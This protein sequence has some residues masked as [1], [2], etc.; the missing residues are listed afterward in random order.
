MDRIKQNQAEKQ[1]IPFNPYAT[2]PSKPLKKES[3]K[4]NLPLTSAAGAAKKRPFHGTDSSSTNDVLRVLDKVKADGFV[5][6]KTKT[7]RINGKINA[8]VPKSFS[9][10]ICYNYP[11]E[12]ST[13]F[14]YFGVYINF[15]ARTYFPN[16]LISSLLHIIL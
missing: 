13:Y 15:F 9:C 1:K 10:M 6:Q 14:I 16:Q 12:V 5:Q 3:A 7:D 8:N 4:R 11:E 2:K